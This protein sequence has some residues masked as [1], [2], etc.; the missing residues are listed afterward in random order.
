MQ[1]ALF[2]RATRAI[3]ASR[4]LRDQHRQVT[5]QHDR[6]LAA[7]RLAVMDSAMARSEIKAHRDNRTDE[8]D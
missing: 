3:E 1:N 4:V 7:A 5:E 6:T 2:A 8:P